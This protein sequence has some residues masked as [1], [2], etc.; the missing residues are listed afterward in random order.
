MTLKISDET[1][2]AIL[3]K[4]EADKESY[5]ELAERFDISPTTIGSIVRNPTGW[6]Q[7][8]RDRKLGANLGG[9]SPKSVPQYYCDGCRAYVTFR[10]CVSCE[11]NAVKERQK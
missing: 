7:T 2:D 4:R 9:L 1:V 11:A 8:K 10:P 6:R 3:A 5:R